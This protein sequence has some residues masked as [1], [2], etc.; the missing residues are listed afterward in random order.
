VKTTRKVHLLL[1]NFNKAIRELSQS[2][3]NEQFFG[4]EA[5][6]DVLYKDGWILGYKKHNAKSIVEIFLKYDINNKPV[7]TRVKGIYKTS[8]Q[9][10]IRMP[11]LVAD[12]K[13]TAYTGIIRTAKFGFL[14]NKASLKSKVG[15]FY[16]AKFF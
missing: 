10:T 9:V 6:L 5:I 11:Q 3:I 2:F 4:I 8:L 16:L 14:T 1:W 13:D 12:N 7:L 15:G